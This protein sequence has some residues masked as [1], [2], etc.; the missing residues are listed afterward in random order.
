M[1]MIVFVFF[2]IPA[3][4]LLFFIYSLIS[5]CA[6]RSK[7]KQIPGSIGPEELQRRKRWLIVTGIISV[8]IVGAAT[9]FIVTLMI[10]IAHM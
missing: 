8:V 10:A 2:G 6:G 3:L 4:S 9:W 5:Y 7:E 1:D